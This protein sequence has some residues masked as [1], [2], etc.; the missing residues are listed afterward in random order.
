MAGVVELM[1]TQE[2]LSVVMGVL[3]NFAAFTQPVPGSIAM[4]ATN[5][6]SLCED[7]FESDE[8]RFSAL[9]PLVA[10]LVFRRNSEFLAKFKAQAAEFQK[11]TIKEVRTSRYFFLSCL[12]LKIN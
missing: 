1:L 7:A 8:Q 6:A 9:L 3:R 12:L 11:A 10:G 4:A 5:S 2:F